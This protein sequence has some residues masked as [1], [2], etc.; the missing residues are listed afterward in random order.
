MLSTTFIIDEKGKKISAIMPI[1]KYEQMLKELEDLEDI[2][3]YD[4]AM[5]RKQKFVSFDLVSK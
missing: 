2:R 1:K 5:S 3:A 4:K